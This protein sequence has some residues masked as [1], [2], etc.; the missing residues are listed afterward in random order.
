MLVRGQGLAKALTLGAGAGAALR[1]EQTGT[2]EHTVDA[3]GADC[4]QV[5]VDHHV[6]QA[7]VALE[8]VL[9]GVSD[10]GALLLFEKPEVA[11]NPSIMF[12]GLAVALPPVVE[13][14]AGQAQPRDHGGDGHAG[15][16][17]P[18][19]YEVDH[20]IA[21]VRLRPAVFQLRPSFF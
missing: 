1:A 6:A 8:G 15:L 7:P 16:L 2:L 11:A 3:G 12:V 21:Q 20:L 18:F 17:R 4:G 10:D 14:A 5:R 13:F 9:A 19:V